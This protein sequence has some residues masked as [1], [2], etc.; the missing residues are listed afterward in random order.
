MEHEIQWNPN[1]SEWVCTQCHRTSDHT[2][3]RDAEFELMQFN[4]ASAQQP[5]SVGNPFL[6]KD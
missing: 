5:V 2:D 4:C 6:S 3:R 1:A